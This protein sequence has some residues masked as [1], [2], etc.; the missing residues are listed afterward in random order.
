M[1]NTKVGNFLYSR[2]DLP[3]Y[4]KTLKSIG[5][6]DGGVSLVQIAKSPE[7]LKDFNNDEMRARTKAGVI[8]ANLR[9]RR[10]IAEF[11]ASGGETI[12]RII[13]KAEAL[14]LIKN[15]SEVQSKVAELTVSSQSVK[16]TEN[17]AV[18]AKTEKK[19][20]ATKDKVVKM[21]KN[22]QTG[23]IMPFGV[24][25]PS[26]VKIAFECNSEGLLKYPAKA[27][28]FIQ[29]G[30][31][32]DS[33]LSK[34]ELLDLVRLLRAQN[35]A[36]TS[37]VKSL[38]EVDSVEDSEGSD[39]SDESEDADEDDDSIEDSDESDDDSDDEADDEQL[40]A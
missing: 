39:E 7:I 6:S 15:A 30:E 21:F 23:E 9:M 24:G 32:D 27:A 5:R 35:D 40:A 4:A 20:M 36:L 26:A 12:Y 14:E 3:M 25:R 10:V 13:N 1:S 18:S 22:P 19:A 17:K 31:K 34:S 2:N 28:A 8:V 38:T 33:K 11:R 29:N 37:M 16:V